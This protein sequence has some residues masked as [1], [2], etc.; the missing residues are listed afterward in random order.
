MS[1]EPTSAITI[2]GS[3]ERT[4]TPGDTSGNWNDGRAVGTAPMTGASVSHSTPMSVPTASATRVE[5][6][7][8]SNFLGHSRATARVA[9]AME[10]ALPSKCSTTPEKLRSV[11]IVPPAAT[12]APRNGRVCTSMIITPTPV[13][14][15]D[16]TEYGVYV[17]KR[18]ILSRPSMI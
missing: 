15:P 11:A 13:I 2:A 10:R 3:M 17:T 6:R 16:M 5:G 14:N 8:L 9:A 4:S 1:T 7:Y 12:G 18:P